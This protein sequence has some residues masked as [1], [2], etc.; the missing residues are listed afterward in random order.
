M[1]SLTSILA[2][3]QVADVQFET[4]A[5]HGEEL[6]R[7]DLCK[8]TRESAVRDVE[9]TIAKYGQELEYLDRCMAVDA[10]ACRLLGIEGDATIS[11]VEKLLAAIRVA[12]QTDVR[13]L[14]QRSAGLMSRGIQPEL[15]A[16]AAR[17]TVLKADRAALESDFN[18]P[19]EGCQGTAGKYRESAQ[20]I[21]RS[22]VY[23]FLFPNYRAARR[24]YL[25]A[26]T[27]NQKFEKTSAIR[28]LEQI[29]DQLEAEEAFL[30]D[31]IFSVRLGS[32]FKGMNTD[33]QQLQAVVDY[34]RTVREQISGFDEFE[35]L[36]RS[37]LLESETDRVLELATMHTDGHEEF[38]RSFS[39]GIKEGSDSI[40]WIIKDRE[41]LVNTLESTRLLAERIAFSDTATL[42]DIEKCA[43]LFAEQGRIQNHLA[44][45]HHA[46]R[47][48][49]I[50]DDADIA[51]D[52]IQAAIDYRQ[53]CDA[54]SGIRELHEKLLSPTAS[55]EIPTLKAVCSGLDQHISSLRHRIE[56]AGSEPLIKTEQFFEGN[57]MHRSIHALALR[58]TH[59]CENAEALRP[60]IQRNYLRNEVDKTA[61]SSLLEAFNKHPRSARPDL[62]SACEYVFYRTLARDAYSQ[63]PDLGKF[64]GIHLSELRSRFQNLDRKVLGLSQLKL[65]AELC[66]R[67]IKQGVGV[68]RKSEY[69]DY[70]LI[71]NEVGKSRRLIP[72]RELV[73]RAGTALQQL[74]PC[75]M[76]SPLSVA[77][78]LKPGTL[79]FDM[80]VIDEASQMRPEDAISAILRGRQ[81]VVVGDPM[82]LPPSSFFDRAGD[83]DDEDDDD[84]PHDESI[85]DI[86]LGVFRPAR[87]LRWHYRSRDENLISFSNREFYDEKLIIFPSSGTISDVGLQTGVIVEDEMFRGTYK[88][89]LNV[90][91]AALVAAA[92]ERFAGDHPKCSL[93]VIA[94]NQKQRD[95]IAA[96]VDKLTLESMVLARYREDWDNQIESFFV[97]KPGKRSRGRERRHFYFNRLWP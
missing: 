63:N 75:F 59:A 66:T 2:A 82:Q 46:R 38:I 36:I 74:K 30:C 49:G 27:Q 20:V 19:S 7:R 60:W 83:I 96:E 70:K 58:L 72:I 32:A 42:S 91:E 9:S 1:E 23:S 15:D 77:Q 62:V 57:W 84:L 28:S 54:V 45:Q 22:G 78:Y 6:C 12:S 44:D 61:A 24:T 39:S 93:G 40:D 13:I 21:K 64:D 90:D 43:K 34:A 26:C 94:M 85:L 4:I 87:D 79:T 67:P 25:A 47:I 29:A 11:R 69:T 35:P 33:F 73:Q 65:A 31:S 76:M 18:F 48:F 80:V 5:Q 3:S 71:L 95:L 86:A 89:G 10:A 14:N 8:T 16:A 37:F 92:V 52:M 56:S 55:L 51:V 97:K 88:S 17:A 68:G 41:L 50:D 81:V 53:H